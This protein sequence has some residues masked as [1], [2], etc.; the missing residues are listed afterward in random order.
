MKTN[1]IRLMISVPRG[2]AEVANAALERQGFGP[3]SFQVEA[4][5]RV[6]CDLPIA[7]NAIDGIVRILRKATGLTATQIKT[8]T[9]AG[10]ISERIKQM[11]AA[12]GVKVKKRE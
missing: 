8:Y 5:T 11:E 10:K 1:K 9:A 2:R 12:E 3:D 4:G 6:I 7:P